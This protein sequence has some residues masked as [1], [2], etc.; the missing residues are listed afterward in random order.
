MLSAEA[1]RMEAMAARGERLG[2]DDWG[3]EINNKFGINA[4]GV[5]CDRLGRL[6]DRLGLERQ[7]KPIEES[8]VVTH[9]RRGPGRRI[10]P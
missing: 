10:A 2:K 6:F 4:Y 5:I 9:F 1:E 3:N 7:A 8:D